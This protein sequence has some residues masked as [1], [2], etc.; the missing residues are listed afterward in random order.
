MTYF[1][2]KYSTTK[3][4]HF[5]LQTFVSHDVTNFMTHV[6]CKRY[7]S[8]ETSDLIREKYFSLTVPK[9]DKFSAD[10]SA[11]DVRGRNIETTVFHS[12]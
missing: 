9:T 11:N 1:N 5:K 4:L 8:L 6:M 7:I 2:L 3:K 10:A 12:F